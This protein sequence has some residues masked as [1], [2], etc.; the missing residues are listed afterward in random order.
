MTSTVAQPVE[1]QDANYQRAM[2]SLDQ[3]INKLHRCSEEEKQLLR[4]DLHKLR[5]MSEKLASGRIEIVVFGEISTGKSALINALVGHDVT[6]VD[7]QGGWTKEIW[8][9]AWEGAGYR[10][11]GL[12]DSEVVLIDTPGLNEVGGQTRADMAR[13]SAARADLIMF[14]TDSDLNE[15]EFSALTTL[16]ATNKPL[17]VVLN[18]IDLYS[19]E[20][21]ERLFQVLRDERLNKIVDADNIVETSADPRDVEYVIESA[22]G[23]TRSE[24]RKPAPDIESLK[25]RILEVLEADGLALIALNAAM[26]A[27]DKSDRVATLRVQ[28]R[29]RCANQVIWTYTV[30]KSAA[31]ALN[32]VP[33]VDTL[34]GVAVDATMVATLAQVY[35]LE[36]STAHARV[37]VTSIARAAG[38]VMLAE[39][40]TWALKAFTLGYGTIWTAIPQGAAAGYGSFIVGQAAR[41]YFEHGASWGN[42]GPKAVVHRILE[43]TNKESVLVRLKTELRKKLGR[44][45]HIPPED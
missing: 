20:Q 36:M 33:V 25:A 17:I 15:T 34:G 5:K 12:A 21:R 24:W 26:Y 14:V 13:E 44:N 2:A 27:A 23:K 3:T 31:V 32:P 22:N 29:E 28:L 37:L 41:Y 7:V 9:V 16:A 38:W 40:G 42:E 43:E 10:V 30:I 39:V 4:D 1:L 19:P 18:K 35:G 8:H 11:P 6:A 45:V